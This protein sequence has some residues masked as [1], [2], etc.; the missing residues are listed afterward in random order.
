[1]L[2]KYPAEQQ[3]APGAMLGTDAAAIAWD[4]HRLYV[5][6]VSSAFTN[7]FE[8]LHI[9]LE[10]DALGAPVASMGKEYSG[11]VPG[12]PFTATHLIGV[13]QTSDGGGG[14]YDGVFVPYA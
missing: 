3:L 8:P 14:A 6:V 1:D 12:V 9:Y 13:R 2:A 10:T 11:L 4:A 7:P 5:T